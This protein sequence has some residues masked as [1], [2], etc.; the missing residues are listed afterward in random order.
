VAEGEFFVGL[1]NIYT[2]DHLDASEYLYIYGFS[3]TW[4]SGD[5]CEGGVWRVKAA[6][7][8][9]RE[10]HKYAQVWGGGIPIVGP[11]LK[12]SLERECFVGLELPRVKW[13]PE[14]KCPAELWQVHSSIM[15]PPCRTRI[16]DDGGVTYFK[17][18]NGAKNARLDFDKAAVVALGKF[19]IAVI[20]EK[21]GP[22]SGDQYADSPKYVISQRFRRA[23]ITGGVAEAGY[24]VVRLV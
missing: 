19:D 14:G 15:M 5:G 2:Q 17:E 8:N 18:E 20:R 10:P 22:Y 7:F 13:V 4:L 12:E 3:H 16:S 23:F 6:S 21:V 9:K 1:E 24:G 11:K